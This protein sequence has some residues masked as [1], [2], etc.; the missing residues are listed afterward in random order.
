VLTLVSG[1]VSRANNSTTLMAILSFPLLLPTLLLTIGIS[2]NAIDGIEASL[3][4][5]KLL[6]LLS[7]DIIV[8]ATAYMLFPFVWRN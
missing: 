8:V 7:I 4:N 1:I 2:K 6:T 5:P 3:M